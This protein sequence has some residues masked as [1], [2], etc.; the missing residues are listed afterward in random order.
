M[1]IRVWQRGTSECN[2][3]EITNTEIQNFQI[4]TVINTLVLEQIQAIIGII[5][6]LN[7][8]DARICV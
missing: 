5:D 4:R 7:E 3:P 1:F 2:I 6:Y 8:S